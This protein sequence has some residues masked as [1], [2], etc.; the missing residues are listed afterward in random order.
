MEF[1]VSQLDEAELAR[2]QD[3]G[4]ESQE[5]IDAAAHLVRVFDAGDDQDANRR[6][7]DVNMMTGVPDA[8]GYSEMERSYCNAIFGDEKCGKFLKPTSDMQE[9]LI[10]KPHDTDKMSRV[11]Q[12]IVGWKLQFANESRVCRPHMPIALHKASAK[13]IGDVLKRAMSQY[14][15]ARIAQGARPYSVLVHEY[16]ALQFMA[17]ANALLVNIKSTKHEACSRSDAGIVTRTEQ[18]SWSIL[19]RTSRHPRQ[20]KFLAVKRIHTTDLAGEIV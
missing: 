9:C 8:S 15:R 6:I 7:D 19:A 11:Q 5:V 20:R 2:L 1:R 18:S 17:V 12:V 4:V 10:I 16:L 14:N 3:E 13:L